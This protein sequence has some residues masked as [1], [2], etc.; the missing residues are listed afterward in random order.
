MTMQK[1]YPIGSRIEYTCRQ[2]GDLPKKDEKWRGATV[3]E[4][5]I[6]MYDDSNSIWV[7]IDGHGD[8]VYRIGDFFGYPTRPVYIDVGDLE[9]DL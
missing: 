4:C 3:V 6:Y 2:Y 1:L 8:N 9:D 5:P 7:T